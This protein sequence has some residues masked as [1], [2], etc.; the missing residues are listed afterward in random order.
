MSR[1]YHS[2]KQIIDL[3]AKPDRGG[4]PSPAPNAVVELSKK[5]RAAA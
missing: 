2:I 3:A 4:R 1:R 5:D